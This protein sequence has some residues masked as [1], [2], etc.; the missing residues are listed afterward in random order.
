M[1]LMSEGAKAMALIKCPYCG[2][3]ISDKATK[4]VHCGATLENK[5]AGLVCPECGASLKGDESVCPNCGCPLNDAGEQKDTQEDEHQAAESGDSSEDSAENDKDAAETAVMPHPVEEGSKDN[6]KPVPPEAADTASKSES[7]KPKDA[8]K[9]PD[10]K[11]RLIIGVVCAVVAVVVA[12]AGINAANKAAEEK[13]AEE[14]AEEAAAEEAAKEQA[15]KDYK[16]SYKTAAMHLLQYCTTVEDAGNLTLNLWHDAIFHSSSDTTS[17]YVDGAEDFNAALQN[18]Y[19]DADFQ[20]KIQTIKSNR[21]SAAAEIKKLSDYPEGYETQYSSL[22]DF[23]DEYMKFSSMVV[24]PSGSY[25]TYSSEFQTA[26]TD[27]VNKFDSV[28]PYFD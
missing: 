19:A 9:V 17:K 1:Q 22:K 25:S 16:S 10:K 8:K 27:C 6:E 26:D 21:D 5:S 2:Q 23:Y 13:A 28:R 11:K 14:A 20:K 18:L 4:C 3:P 15:E 24:D 12:I 7:D